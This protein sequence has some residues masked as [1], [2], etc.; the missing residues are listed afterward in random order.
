MQARDKKC[1]FAVFPFLKTSGEICIG[2]LMFR[3]TDITDGLS[4]EQA[5]CVNEIKNMLFLRDNFRIKSAAYAV[6]PFVE[7]NHETADI[8]Y[9]KNVQAVVAYCYASP[10]HEFGDIFLSFEHASMALFTQGLVP[11]PLIHSDFHVEEIEPRSDFLANH[12]GEIEGY[13]GLYN[14]R[15]HFWATKSSRLYGPKPYLTLNHAQDLASD[16]K[17]SEASRV[18][19]QLLGE[20]LRKPNTRSSSRI[21]TALRWFNAANNEAN[22]QAAA[23]VNLSIAFEALLNLPRDEKTD[24]LTDSISLLLG[25]TP[26]LDIWARQFYNTR[27][28]IVHEGNAKQ[29]Q[30]IATDTLKKKS[31]GPFYQS[32]LSYGRQIFQLCLG[33][34]LVGNNLAERAGLE[35]KFIT[36]QER[37]ESICKVLTDETMECSERIANIAPI[38]KAI[39]QYRYVS[40][41]NLKLETMIGAIRNAAKVLLGIDEYISHKLKEKLDQIVNAERTSNHLQELEA[42]HSLENCLNDKTVLTETSYGEV[43]RNIVKV[44]WD[45]VFMHYYW[46]KKQSSDKKAK[47]ESSQTG[48]GA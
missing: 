3:S 36:N 21:F 7:L 2:N 47:V 6:V 29:V 17:R 24:R 11:M 13:A 12:R 38:V 5:S 35:E 45:Y 4:P 20:L 34:L 33:T 40:E 32:L 31:E 48:D 41:S 42:L 22:D 8:G 43:V 10:R 19:Y 9:L 30:F 15:H 1:S 23:I 16:F 28:R 25:R 37:F 27:S 18:D 44:V 39:Q 26:R 46:L 14:F